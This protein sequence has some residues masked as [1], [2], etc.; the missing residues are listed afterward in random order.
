MDVLNI[1]VMKD[2]FFFF[3]S[4]KNLDEG[5]FIFLRIEFFFFLKEV[6]KNVC[7]FIFDVNFVKYL[8]RFINM[9]QIFVI[10]NEILEMDFKLFVVLIIIVE[11]GRS[12]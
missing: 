1:L 6:D 3:L 11:I 7:E 9:C 8:L 2:K 12:D 4:F 5:N 10:N